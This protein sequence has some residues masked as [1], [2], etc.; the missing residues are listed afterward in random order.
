MS[1]EPE[2]RRAL[3]RERTRFLRAIQRLAPEVLEKLDTNVFPLFKKLFVMSEPGI[4]FSGAELLLV[5]WTKPTEPPGPCFYSIPGSAHTFASVMW[6]SPIDEVVRSNSGAPY[7][8]SEFKVSFGLDPDR[9][10]FRAGVLNW[11]DAFCL[12]EDWILDAVLGTLLFWLQSGSRRGWYLGSL[13]L[14]PGA[15]D[16]ANIPRF[17]F[18]YTWNGEPWDYVEALLKTKVAEFKAEFEKHAALS[19]RPD[20]VHECSNHHEWLALYQ[21]KR[22]SYARILKWHNTKS[23]KAIADETG[24]KAGLRSAADRIGLKRRPGMRGP[25]RSPKREIL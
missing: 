12:D 19:F 8:H 9:L 11:A 15:E 3:S 1:E 5:G 13:A 4:C 18:E 16:F 14:Q 25:K 2:Q 6:R 7:W 22:W 17:N 10:D 21:C 23:E 24:I 20:T